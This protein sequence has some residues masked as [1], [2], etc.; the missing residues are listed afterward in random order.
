MGLIVDSRIRSPDAEIPMLQIEHMNS[1]HHL[2]N[3]MN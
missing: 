2:S 3:V 1:A